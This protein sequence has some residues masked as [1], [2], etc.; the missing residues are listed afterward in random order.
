MTEL[1]RAQCLRRLRYWGTCESGA[2]SG[3]QGAP[4]GSQGAPSGGQLVPW[5]AA[6]RSQVVQSTNSKQLG[7]ARR[8]D[9]E[10]SKRLGK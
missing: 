8:G 3:S 7:R 4:R 6:R 5:A 2:P 9:V 1:L 10:W